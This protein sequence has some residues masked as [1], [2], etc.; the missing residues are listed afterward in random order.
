MLFKALY[1]ED[2]SVNDQV[3][4]TTI[5]EENGKDMPNERKPK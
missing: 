2:D 1:V 5:K 4:A 3:V